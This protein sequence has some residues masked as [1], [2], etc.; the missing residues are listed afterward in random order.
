MKLK[1]PSFEK[2]GKMSEIFSPEVAL[3][4][5]RLFSEMCKLFLD[6]VPEVIVVYFSQL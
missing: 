3:S 2:C 1:G 4:D 6:C 5:S